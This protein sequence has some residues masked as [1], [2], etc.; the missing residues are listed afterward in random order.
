MP[1][2][3][4]DPIKYL[5]KARK[6]VAPDRYEK[7]TPVKKMLRST[8]F[9]PGGSGLWHTPPKKMLPATLQWASYSFFVNSKSPSMP[10]KKIMVL[11]NDFGSK[12]G[13]KAARN[14]PYENLKFPTWRNL[15]EFLHRVGIK[16]KNCFFTNAYMGLR[17]A[18]GP[19]GPSP[20]ADDPKFVKR[21]KS[22]FLDKQITVQK[23]RLILVLGAEARKFIAQLSPDLAEWKECETFTEL[24]DLGPVKK[25]RFNNS[26][27]VTVVALVHP[28]GR[29]LGNTLKNRHYHGEKGEDAES[30]MLNR[31]LKKSG[32]W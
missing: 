27:P 2:Q 7:V 5:F 4:R 10:K 21:C 17:V 6:N 16:P 25:V 12:D 1:K 26:K 30:K 19:T 31:A 24:D 13:Y 15:L 32:L 29:K 18:G 8:A 20:G 23:P 9:F 14:N 11:G 28:A 22:F 3:K